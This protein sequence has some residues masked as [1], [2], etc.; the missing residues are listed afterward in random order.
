MTRSP[1]VR[2]ALAAALALQIGLSGAAA[3][4]EIVPDEELERARGGVMIA[5]GLAFEFGAVVRTFENGALS[6]ETQMTWTPEG[7]KLDQQVGEGVVRLSDAELGAFAGAGDLYRTAGG[8]LVT[9]R[10]ADGQLVNLIMNTQSD[11]DLR[12]ETAITLTL[13]G[14]QGQQADM[15]RQL[16]GLRLADELAG[17]ALSALRH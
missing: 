6:L 2:S 15:V 16:T 7:L 13:P 5:G 14:F 1:F 11:L 12:Q 9:H 4:Y 17:G 3:A 8:S 10:G